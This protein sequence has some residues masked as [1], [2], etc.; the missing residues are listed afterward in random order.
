M[1]PQ[2]LFFDK[3]ALPQNLRKVANDFSYEENLES[4]LKEEEEQDKSMFEF[5]Y[6]ME[7]KY[8]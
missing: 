1:K 2:A 4:T 8:S 5:A 6:K 7:I 3:R